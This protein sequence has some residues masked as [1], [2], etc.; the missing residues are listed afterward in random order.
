M[1]YLETEVL[2]KTLRAIGKRADCLDFLYIIAMDFDDD[3][4]METL[5]EILT[6][7][8]PFRGKEADRG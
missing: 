5:G 3:S 7:L 4:T 1:P 2:Y 8:E 6:L